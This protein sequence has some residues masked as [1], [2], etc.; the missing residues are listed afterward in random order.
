MPIAD[1]VNSQEEIQVARVEPDA[2]WDRYA[3]ANPGASLGH[4]RGWQSV[5]ADA[6]GIDTHHFGACDKTGRLRGIL[7]L[8]RFRSLTGAQSWVSL[9]FLDSAGVLA[10]GAD[11]EAAL[12]GAARAL[13]GPIELR[14][15]AQLAA[16]PLE[17]SSRVELTLDLG[18]GAEA[19]WRALPAK[20]RNQTRKAWKEGLV[21]APPDE[22]GIGD[23]HRVHCHGMRALG[24]PPHSE[25]F[26]RSVFEAFGERARFIVVRDGARAV[27][28]LVAIE[29]AGLVTVPWASTLAS[30]R[31]RCPNN[32]LYWEAIR[33]AEERGARAFS[34]GRSPWGSGTHRF[35]RGWGAREAP[36]HWL[37]LDARGHATVAGSGGESRLLHALSQVWKHL[38]P[39]LCDVCGPHVRRRIAS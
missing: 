1:R 8:A 32:L 35:K 25:R 30:D 27:G 12:L 13:G 5:F 3:E 16:L 21:V 9:P 33:W 29:F 26:F 6:Y 37:Q 11:A 10:D 20:V 7:A 22:D 17:A 31:A 18:G 36:L 14:Q 38:P 34:F 19:R 28:G 24:S 4:A 2:A 15:S 39:A 23:F